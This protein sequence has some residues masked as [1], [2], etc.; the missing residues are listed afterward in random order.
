VV[1]AQRGLT[2]RQVTVRLDGGKLGI[3][4]P[5]DGAWMTGPTALVFEGRLA[6]DFLGALS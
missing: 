2:G 1:T 6:A 4:W 5:D 3:A